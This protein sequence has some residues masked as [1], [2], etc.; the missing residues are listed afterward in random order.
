VR[1]IITRDKERMVSFLVE[2]DNAPEAI[3]QKFLEVEKILF[4]IAKTE[5]K[6]QGKEVTE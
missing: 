2:G 1:T 6:K 4:P 5:Q 3:A